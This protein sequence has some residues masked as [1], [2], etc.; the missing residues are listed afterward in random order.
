MEQVRFSSLTQPRRATGS[1]QLLHIHSFPSNPPH[2]LPM[3]SEPPPGALEV[4]TGR[5]TIPEGRPAGPCLSQRERLSPARQPRPGDGPFAT[6]K[7]GSGLAPT[8]LAVLA[9]G[10][11][12]APRLTVQFLPFP[13]TSVHA[14]PDAC[15]ALHRP[16]NIGDF[17]PRP[18]QLDARGS[19][20][21]PDSAL[22]RRRPGQGGG[23]RS[24]LC[25][26]KTKG[27]YWDLAMPIEIPA[28]PSTS[29]I[30]PELHE[31]PTSSL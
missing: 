20:A 31:A 5:D 27:F 6:S 21:M 4:E 23:C 25:A 14:D 10:N 18:G 22:A 2:H 13:R 15:G 28:K 1:I 19:C 24:P 12:P 17:G 30:A 16:P 29:Q 7:Q 3:V 11:K 8:P 26:S 9:L